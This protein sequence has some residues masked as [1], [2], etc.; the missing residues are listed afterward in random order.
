MSI[1]FMLLSCLLVLGL[2][3]ICQDDANIGQS[4]LICKYSAKWEFDTLKSIVKAD[5]IILQIGKE[6]SKNYSYYTFQS[7]SLSNTPNAKEKW[8]MLFKQAMKK[9]AANKGSGLIVCVNS[10]L[11]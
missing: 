9:A 11:S 5:I 4:N 1:K 7:D 8:R 10:D 2:N 6:I 3:A